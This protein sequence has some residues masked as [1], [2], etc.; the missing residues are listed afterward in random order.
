MAGELKILKEELNRLQSDEILDEGVLS[1]LGNVI[2]STAKVV[3]NILAKAD[4]KG[5]EIIQNLADMVKQVT[6]IEILLAHGHIIK[7]EATKRVMNS[8]M[9]EVLV[10]GVKPS[11]KRISKCIN[12]VIQV[13]GE[14]NAINELLKELNKTDQKKPKMQNPLKE[15]ITSTNDLLAYL[16]KLQITFTMLTDKITIGKLNQMNSG[17]MAKLEKI[18][19]EL[20]KTQ[21]SKELKAYIKTNSAVDKLNYV[22]VDL[23]NNC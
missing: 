1:A 17:E 10:K 4:V 3:G 7:T 6:S 16:Q 5:T 2:N 9:E 15:I 18:F 12:S 21:F 22:L 14:L 11:I 20:V 19:D 13:S 23:G 8:T